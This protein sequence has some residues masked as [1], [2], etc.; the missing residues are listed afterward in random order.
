MVM[1]AVIHCGPISRASIAKQTGLSKQTISEI[2]RQLELEGWVRKTGRTSGHVGR[3]AVTYEIIPDAA[4]II[5]VDLGGTKL[6]AASV[7]LAG[8]IRAELCEPTDHRGGSFIAAQIAKICRAVADRDNPSAGM[9]KL[10]VIGVPGVPD[11]ESG[12]VHMA[13]NIP[14]ID[15]IDIRSCL[16]DEMKIDVILEND[17]NLAVLGEHWIGCGQGIEDLAYISLGTGIGA[18]LMVHGKLLRGARSAAG[19]LGYLPI[20]AESLD[21]ESQRVGALERVVAT[22]G[23]RTRYKEATGRYLDVP[24]IFDAASADDLAAGKVLDE[25]ALYLARAIAAVC[26][27]NDPGKV[28][29]GGS[30]GDR[31]ELI[32]R[33]RV[34]LAHCF[35]CRVDLERSRLGSQ[36]ALAGGAALGLG[37]LHAMLFADGIASPE[38]EI[39]RS[40]DVRF[41]QVVQ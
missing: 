24:E 18:G 21:T 39:P 36:A 32:E 12:N 14:G 28:I 10:A 38:V 11:L 15:R 40:T 2:A 27:V 29:L 30:I 26:A 35:P 4:G 20:G 25:T 16:S 37:E 5:A 9:A 7:D 22:D 17:V 34:S 19:E 31:E 6:R 33:V 41:L 13:P 23:I 8:T 3:S 1:Q